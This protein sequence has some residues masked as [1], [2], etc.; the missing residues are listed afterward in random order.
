MLVPAF[1]THACLGAPYGWSA[2]SSAL[3]REQGPD[4]PSSLLIFLP[5]RLIYVPTFS[6]SFFF[7]PCHNS[8]HSF[9]SSYHTSLTS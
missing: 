2:V 6:L 1:L 9:L 4:T 3:T 8:L 7:P 5:S